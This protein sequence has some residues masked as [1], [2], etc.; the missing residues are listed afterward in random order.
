MASNNGESHPPIDPKIADELLDR[1]S[2]DD[3]F[4]EQFSKDPTSAMASLGHSVP[5]GMEMT[6]MATGELASKEQ[7][8]EARDQLREAM[9]SSA[10][11][12]NPHC[13]DAGTVD[14]LK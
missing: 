9:T 8:A 6:C 4:R 1:L 13:F 2:N 12:S 14:S 11:Y 5:E 10:T 3:A 7:I